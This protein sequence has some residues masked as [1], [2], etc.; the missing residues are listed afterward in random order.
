VIVSRYVYRMDPAG[1]TAITM[2][3]Q[4][5]DALRKAEIAGRLRGAGL[6][7]TPQRVL[8]FQELMS[9][10]DHPTAEDLYSAVKR[11][12]PTLSFNTVYH[13]LQALT[14]KEMIGVIRPVV[15]AARYDPITD[16]HGHFM[17]SKCKRIEDQ[18]M[19]DPNL[20]QIDSEVKASGRYWVVQ[21]QILWVGLCES[22]G[23]AAHP[24]IR[25]PS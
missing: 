25:K 23:K 18:L 10:T 7:A 8:I 1:E 5:E 17:C 24:D 12:H 22:C 15:D 11:V 2:P 3:T 20:K 13:T 14:E 16:L 6:K 21:S 19:E 4:E 9:R